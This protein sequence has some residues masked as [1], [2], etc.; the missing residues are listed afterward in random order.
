MD[1][2]QL[3]I[4]TYGTKEQ[5]FKGLAKKTKGQLAQTDLIMN[6]SGK[7]VSKKQSLLAKAR[8]QKMIHNQTGIFKLCK[9]KEQCECKKPKKEE[10]KPK[11]E[12][13]KPIKKAAYVGRV[14]QLTTKYIDRLFGVEGLSKEEYEERLKFMT[15]VLMGNGYEFSDEDVK[16]FNEEWD[17]DWEAH[18]KH[19]NRTGKWPVLD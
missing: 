17:F 15:G 16:T 12:E 4:P 11:E 14:G 18:F 10:P 2:E 19:F 9:C 1:P 13:P 8:I 3:I 5:V 7:I 6:K